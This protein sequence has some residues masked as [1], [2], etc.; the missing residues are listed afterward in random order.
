MHE[1]AG[2][3]KDQLLILCDKNGNP[4]GEATREACHKGKG[5]T[6]LAFMAFLMDGEGKTILT[7]RSR[8]K[9]LWAGYWD[10]AIVSHVL[11]GETPLTAANRRGKEELGVDV[12]FELLGAFYY[13]QPHGDS[14]ENEYCFV[15]LGTTNEQVSPNPVEIDAVHNVSFASLI[16]DSQKNSNKYTPWLLLSLSKIDALKHL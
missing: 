10:A 11:S 6:H 9:S 15:L 13:F 14:C 7:K 2:E 16:S 3:R 4:I 8:K 12:Q 5:K 1:L